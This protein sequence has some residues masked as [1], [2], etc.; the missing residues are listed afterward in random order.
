MLCRLQFEETTEL[1]PCALPRWRSS[2]T[3]MGLHDLQIPRTRQSKTS[4]DSASF[5][6]NAFLVLL[7]PPGTVEAL[8]AISSWARGTVMK[9]C[10]KSKTNTP[11]EDPWAD[12]AARS[13]PWSAKRG[14]T[15]RSDTVD[16]RFTAEARK[17]WMRRCLREPSG[18]IFVTLPK[19][20]I[21][22]RC[23]KN[24][25]ASSRSRQT[26]ANPA[27]TKPCNSSS[28]S[29]LPSTVSLKDRWLSS[30]KV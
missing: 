1:V 3:P 14:R 17:S 18:L 30:Y 26:R 15:C 29:W 25:S 16:A 27:S 6:S 8:N 28:A 21:K 12:N 2:S 4:P 9:A 11:T 19:G 22:G 23:P 13:N 5:L 10:L 20:L 7:M 24:V